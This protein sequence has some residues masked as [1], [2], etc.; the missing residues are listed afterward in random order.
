MGDPRTVE[1]VVGVERRR[2]ADQRELVVD[3]VTAE[4]HRDRL[5]SQHFRDGAAKTT[6]DVVLFDH[7]DAAGLSCRRDNRLT[8]E[9]LDGVHVDE[10]AV[11]PLGRERLYGIHC[12]SHR[13]PMSDNSEVT[14]VPEDDG[15][16]KLESGEA[17]LIDHSLTATAE[18]EV[19]RSRP[20]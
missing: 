10:P 3:T 19:D 5:L 18:P 7:E 11:Q 9:R 13:K 14:P 16:T 2:R 1:M 6:R 20:G 17:T 4:R 12:C 8:V 15:L